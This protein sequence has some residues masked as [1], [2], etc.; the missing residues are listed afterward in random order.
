[1]PGR[2]PFAVVATVLLLVAAFGGLSVGVPLTLQL[3]SGPVALDLGGFVALLLGYG[4][5]S[6]V[7]AIAVLLRWRRT[8]VGVAIAEG[9]V[10]VAL[11]AFHAGVAADPSLLAVAA[12]S[13]GAALC[14]IVDVR[15]WRAGGR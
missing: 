13:G 14:A 8:T 6:L 7:G 5:V 2:T 15:G 9:V 1:V 12:I 11:L 4:L 3:L 10:A